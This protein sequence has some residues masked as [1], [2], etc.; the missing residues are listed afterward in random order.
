MAS[1]VA[2]TQHESGREHRT[3]LDAERFAQVGKVLVNHPDIVLFHGGNPACGAHILSLRARARNIA[4]VPLR[5]GWERS[6]KASPFSRKDHM[7]EVLPK[8]VASCPGNGINANL[9]DKAYR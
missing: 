9:V 7:L 8:A 1:E 2:H 6:K 5:P 4:Q 3:C